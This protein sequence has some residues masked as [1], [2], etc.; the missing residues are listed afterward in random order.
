MLAVLPPT[1]Y[2]RLGALLSALI[3]VFSLIGLTMHKD[4]YAGVRRRDFYCYYTNL[5]NL[6]VLIY[7]ALIAPRLYGAAR[8]RALIPH[9]EFAVMMSIMLTFFVFHHLLFPS[10][11]GHVRGVPFS[12]EFAILF[13][14]NFI[15]HYLVP[16]LVF[17]YWLL[18]APG[19]AALR[20]ADGLL[21][22]I[23]PLLYLLFIAIRARVRGVIEETGSPYP[24]PFLDVG[25]R[26]LCS[27]L[28]TCAG[29][30]GLCAASGVTVVVVIRLL[31][32]RF[33]TAHALILI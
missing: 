29:L 4:F 14:D 26:G 23:L 17:A 25:R 11:R 10:I 7:F 8:L 31:M 32:A 30:F 33:G 27:V 21:W 16:W 1:A 6:L 20:A 3:V 13:V 22:T 28:R 24:Y 19:K 15:V 2:G 18:C 12:R 9:A 5:S